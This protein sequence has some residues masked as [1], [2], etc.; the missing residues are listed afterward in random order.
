MITIETIGLDRYTIGHY[1]REHT[2]NIASLFE[3]SEDNIS[4][5]ATNSYVFHEGVEQTSWNVLVKISAPH[6][7]E[8]LQ[9]KVA[10]Y[11]LKTL[12]DF[13]IHIAVEFHYFEDDN[14]F[15]H[16]NEDY[17]LFIKDENVVN[18]EESELKEGEE[19]YEG[20]IFENFQ[21]QLE[22]LYHGESAHDEC[23]DEH[24]ECHHHHED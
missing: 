16:H 13:A 2:A 8:I 24:C 7:Y 14:R 1:S 23:D 6:K 15:E 19:L 22:E 21:E 17:P 12:K 18:V 3:T 11:L 10:D 20:N 4:F 9:E 5:V